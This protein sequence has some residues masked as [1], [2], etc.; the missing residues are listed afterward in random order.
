MLVNGQIFWSSQMSLHYNCSSIIGCNSDRKYSQMFAKISESISMCRVSTCSKK[1]Q[2]FHDYFASQVKV[3]SIATWLQ[4]SLHP[5][6]WSLRRFQA[7]STILEHSQALEIQIFVCF[8]YV[9][10]SS[11]SD[12]LQV[13]C[14]AFTN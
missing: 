12:H 11:M 4:H 6:Q 13:I 3:M 14:K 8:L 2:G 1:L 7:I 10:L 9:M 5:S